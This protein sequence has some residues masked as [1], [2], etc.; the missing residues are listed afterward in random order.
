MKLGGLTE[1]ECQK[2]IDREL[3]DLKN[4]IMGLT[5]LNLFGM[6]PLA[7]SFPSMCGENGGFVIPPGVQDTM[8]RI[9]DN[10]LNTLK[11][12]LMIDMNALK[13]FST[14]PRALLAASDP[15]A[16]ADAHKPFV[17]AITDPYKKNCIAMIMDPYNYILNCPASS[18]YVETYP[19]T[20][21]NWVHYGN[22]SSYRTKDLT[23]EFASLTL[24]QKQ[25]AQDAAVTLTELE[26]PAYIKVLKN[27][28]E[29][30][31]LKNAMQLRLQKEEYKLNNLKADTEH[32]MGIA[33]GSEAHEL[34]EQILDRTIKFMNIMI[35]FINDNAHNMSVLLNWEHVFTNYKPLGAFSS[36]FEYMTQ[37]QADI[38]FF[39]DEIESQIMEW[40]DSFEET[41]Q[42]TIQNWYDTT[43][44]TILQVEYNKIMT[45]LNFTQSEK[46]LFHLSDEE[47]VID[48]KNAYDNLPN[49]YKP[50]NFFDS[51]EFLP[52]N[53][54][55]LGSF[56]SDADVASKAVKMNPNDGRTKSIVS[57]YRE[58]N[59]SH[60]KTSLMQKVRNDFLGDQKPTYLDVFSISAE[61]ALHRTY[62]HGGIKMGK[63][64]AKP[65][66]NDR[67]NFPGNINES[68]S[69][70]TDKRLRRFWTLDTKLKDIRND[71]RWWY[72][73]LR[74]FTGCDISSH[75]PVYIRNLPTVLQNEA[76]ILDDFDPDNPEEFFEAVQ[77][78]DDIDWTL[79]NAQ[80]ATEWFHWLQISP[81]LRKLVPMILERI[82]NGFN[83]EFKDK[84][85]QLCYAF[86][87][88]TLAEATGI[89]YDRIKNIF[90]NMWNTLASSAV[91]FGKGQ[92]LH[93]RVFKKIDLINVEEENFSENPMVARVTPLAE[94]P[95]YY[96]HYIVFEKYFRDPDS[97]FNKGDDEVIGHFSGENDLVNKELYNYL[98]ES[99]PKSLGTAAG[100][101]DAAANTFQ[102]SKNCNC[103]AQQKFNTSECY[104]TGR[105]PYTFT[106]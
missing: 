7:N 51:K 1:K 25:E 75:D 12:S 92:Y 77:A 2:Q 61:Q 56:D 33:F 97:I 63:D 71:P 19:I 84:Q 4:K 47:I 94:E 53:I 15:E 58:A 81:G 26:R 67:Q 68:K 10:M 54:S 50:P 79:E 76:D 20:Y 91:A 14:P 66:H 35:D 57:T 90:P 39:I 65:G 106:N 85:H 17:D 6:N 37:G 96:P 36:S 9:T 45:G 95:Q 99:F 24:N 100:M 34:A 82:E 41:Y 60:S 73:M 89:E 103:F 31:D 86:M 30:S 62:P 42:E 78:L 70:R 16:L 18:N 102:D 101:A 22:F 32:A 3:E 40:Y 11:G 88:L 72:H 83:N 49:H 44:E 105:P 48:I 21:G 5:S 64:E 28:L 55:L 13:F 23:L 52:L 38:S 87:D 43:Y 74:C 98:A 8:E 104:D 93:S 59:A 27:Q 46:D 29:A 80:G 69:A